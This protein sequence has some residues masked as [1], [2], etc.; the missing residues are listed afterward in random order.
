LSF[1]DQQNAQT[2]TK[3]SPLEKPDPF[4]LKL[5]FF[6]GRIGTESENSLPERFSLQK[7]LALFLKIL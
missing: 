5:L 2:P 1:P 4:L 3:K 6:T 7:R